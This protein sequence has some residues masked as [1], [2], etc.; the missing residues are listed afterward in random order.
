MDQQ[1]RMRCGQIT[2]VCVR[3]VR[4]QT[5][6]TIAESRS[7]KPHHRGHR[8][9]S[10]A[11]Q[12]QIDNVQCEYVVIVDRVVCEVCKS[13]ND[14]SLVVCVG[15]EVSVEVSEEVGVDAI[16]LT[17]WDLCWLETR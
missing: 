16:G 6:N 8:A 17:H 14:F 9:I 1:Q 12:K 5:T 2:I 11:I 7:S 13:S 15:V 10:H 4:E 3:T